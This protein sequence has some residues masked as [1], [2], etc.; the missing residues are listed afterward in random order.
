ME[1]ELENTGGE[2]FGLINPKV[3][4]RGVI[5][6]DVPENFNGTVTLC[7]K[8]EGYNCSKSFVI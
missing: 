6:F 4:S 7:A 3:V 8:G 2:F 1:S 5:V